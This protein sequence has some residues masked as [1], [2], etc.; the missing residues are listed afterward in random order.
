[1]CLFAFVANAQES[2]SKASQNG[3]RLDWV[4]SPE[5]MPE[6]VTKGFGDPRNPVSDPWD[7]RAMRVAKIGGENSH[8]DRAIRGGQSKQS[9]IP[10]TEDD[11]PA[12]RSSAAIQP[13]IDV[14]VGSTYSAG[15]SG[16]PDGCAAV[17]NAGYTVASN[18]THVEFFDEDGNVLY[19]EGENTFWSILGP[20][21]NIYDPKILYNAVANK[22]ILMALHGSS[23]SLSELYVA[24][25]VSN[26][27]MDGWWY[28]TFD[29]N[30]GALSSWWFDYPSIGHS[31]E[32][33]FISGNMFTDSDAYQATSLFQIEMNDGFTGGSLSFVY[34]SDV[35]QANDQNT[36]TVKPLQYPFGTYGPGIYLASMGN[37]AASVNY[38]NVT[39][40]VDDSPVLESY[41][42][43]ADSWTSPTNAAQGGS[44]D[45]LDTG[46]SRLRSGF[47]G[48]DGILHL[49]HTVE[50]GTSGYAELRYVKVD[51]NDGNAVKSDFGLDNWDY[52]YPWI[53]PWATNAATWDGGIMVGFLRV[54]STTFPEFRCVHMDG[55]LDW[56]GSVGI[57]AGDSPISA[58]GG[59]TDR[60]GDY[61]GGGWREGQTTP[62][63]WLYGQYGQSND[64]ALWL[65]QVVAD[66]EG[67]TD[68]SA[69]NYDPDATLDQGCEYS[70][71]A[72]CT[73]ATACNYD[74]G[75]T[76]DD[77]SCTFPGCT[78]SFACNW[79]PSAGC[80]D[81]SCCYGTCVTVDMELDG[82]F[83]GNAIDYTITDNADGSVVITGGNSFITSTQEWC[84]DPGCYTFEIT[85]D[86]PTAAWEIRFSPFF[87]L[88]G[89]DYTI[90][91]GT[92]NFS[93]EFIV[94][95]GGEASGCTDLSACNYDAT[96]ICDNGSCCYDNCLTI[97]MTDSFGDGWNNNLWEVIDP[98]D[99]S[100]V[101]TGTLE[102]GSAG[103]DVACLA[104]GCYDFQINSSSGAFSSEIGWT[105]L[106]TDAEVDPAGISTDVVTFT[107]GGGGDDYACTDPT[108]CNYSAIAICDDGSCCYTNCATLIKNDSFGDGWNGGTLDL[109]D[110]E[111]NI[112]NSFEMLNGS[113]EVESL[114]LVDGCYSLV[115][116]AG[117]FPTEVSWTLT[118]DATGNM[119]G[120]GATYN[121]QF[122]INGVD[123][124]TDPAA[125]N[126]DA[127]ATCDDDSCNYSGCIDPFACNFN[128]LAGCDDGSCAYECYGCTYADAENYDPT[129]TV[130]DSSCTFAPCSN[131]CAADLNGDGEIGTPDLLDL[132]GSFGV[133][134]P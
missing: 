95:D 77:G 22:F 80:N 71:C 26:N 56:G 86:D 93:G 69:C 34:W 60:W 4:K 32:D 76:I 49:A 131:D 84:M 126:Y 96:A 128:P 114:C 120:G 36:F 10:N 61:I 55:D 106:G 112:L 108:A 51:I 23:S 28:Y 104:A 125:C 119:V 6:V 18:N 88:I 98:A 68:P 19:S 52:A 30:P 110:A 109:L 72:G 124:C 21:A 75:A 50:R 107:I 25:S 24:F 97:D 41:S 101:A 11:S 8:M 91:E 81:G 53:V 90:Y 115:F 85:C 83:G 3:G 105:L 89:F 17:S 123:G 58:N 2:A 111:G 44:T 130:D 29:G 122:S 48:G 113:Q 59:A 65:A 121:E 132:L 33:L 12:V 82:L 7:I 9:V 87:I 127:A 45:Q 39:A 94:G 102:D 13:L 129:A 67:C 62:E 46:G 35:N 116:N 103:I 1:M 15:F 100:V 134:C 54:S 70:T 118:M 64:H 133:T 73:T 66:I 27:P 37:D 99:G 20:T 92:G 63:V 79:D 57:R 47:Y 16:V 74:A 43:S 78:D 5:S 117:G 38:F 31:A 42:V 40:N 14:E